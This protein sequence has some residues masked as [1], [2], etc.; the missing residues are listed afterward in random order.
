MTAVINPRGSRDLS[1]D[2]ETVFDFVADPLNDPEWCPLVAG[3]ELVSGEAGTAGA[4]YRWQQVLGE[5]QSA[6]MDFVLAVVDRPRRL[7]WEL[8]HDLFTYHSV[9]TFEALQQGGTRVEQENRTTVKGAPEQAAAELEAQGV[10]VME[11]QFDN[12]ESALR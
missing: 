7:E 4:V 10:A 5:D 6:P 1:V 3:C 12:L 11:Q 8:D 9:M 2:R